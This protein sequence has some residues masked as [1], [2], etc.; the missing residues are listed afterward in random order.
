[1]IDDEFIAFMIVI[2]LEDEEKRQNVVG[3]FSFPMQSLFVNDHIRTH[4]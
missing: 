2:M 4:V 3:S 1:M